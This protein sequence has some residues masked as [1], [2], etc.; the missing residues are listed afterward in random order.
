[1]IWLAAYILTIPLANWAITQ[2]GVVPVGFGLMAPAG[3]AFAGLAFTLRDLTHES[4]GRW[5]TLAA[6]GVGALLSL[7]VS[8]PFVAAASALAFLVSELA[9]FAVYQPLRRNYRMLAV[10]LSNS[11]GL[12]IDS[13]LFLWLLLGDFSFL[14]G[15]IV[16]KAYMTVAAL[17]ALFV[18][19][20]RGYVLARHASAALAGGD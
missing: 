18:W 2:Y 11:V 7:A 5:W 17:I 13:A 4:L 12:A 3:V 15:Q 1:M 14:P 9:D 20:N 10:G 8:A 19:R 16:G 6:I